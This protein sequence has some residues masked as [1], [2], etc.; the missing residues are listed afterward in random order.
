[1]SD[2]PETA[3]LFRMPR[4][5]RKHGREV[6][7]IFPCEPADAA[8]TLM[9]CYSRTGQHSSCSLDWLKATRPAEPAEYAALQRDLERA[10][11][12]YRLKVYQ[13]IQPAHREAFADAV[14]G[15]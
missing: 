2:K 4:N 12:G 8:G 10:P 7:A 5:T 15:R 6:T 14:K 1:M 9:A 13:K 3:V 11:Y